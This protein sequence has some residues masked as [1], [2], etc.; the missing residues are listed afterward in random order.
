MVLLCDKAV[1]IFFY[2]T[3]P[4]PLYIGKPKRLIFSAFSDG[5]NSD[6]LESGLLCGKEL[7]GT[8]WTDGGIK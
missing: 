1:A 4:P 5:D 7:P 3:I 6:V 2:N 8:D